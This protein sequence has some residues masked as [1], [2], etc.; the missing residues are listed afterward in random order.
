MEGSENHP[1]GGGLNRGRMRG[2][3]GNG[4]RGGGGGSQRSTPGDGG[5]TESLDPAYSA[6]KRTLCKFY[7]EKRECDRPDAC[8]RIHKCSR[9]VSAGIA[10]LQDHPYH[11]HR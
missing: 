3:N 7:N 2:G 4:G 6:I 9:K 11:E 8:S 5:S 10:C 1:M